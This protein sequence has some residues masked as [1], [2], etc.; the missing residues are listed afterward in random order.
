MSAIE[1]SSTSW[2]DEDRLPVDAHPLEEPAHD[3]EPLGLR[4]LLLGGRP[5]GGWRERGRRERDARRHLPPAVRAVAVVAGHP[6][7][8]PVEPGVQRVP[9]GAIAEQAP[10]AGEPRGHRVPDGTRPALRVEER[11]AVVDGHQDVLLDVLE[12]VHP[13]AEPPDGAAE[14]GELGLVDLLE[15]RPFG[16]LRVRASGTGHTLDLRVRL[17]DHLQIDGAACVVR[18]TSAARFS[19]VRICPRSR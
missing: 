19:R 13:H 1:M 11:E 6:P 10:E 2:S 14:E 7:G 9:A 12:V 4:D 15:G 5:L 17:A 16:R 3:L 8:D 18:T